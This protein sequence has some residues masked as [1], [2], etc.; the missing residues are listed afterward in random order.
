MTS[1]AHILRCFVLVVQLFLYEDVSL[2]QPRTA[3]PEKVQ[4][5]SSQSKRQTKVDQAQ[6]NR[7]QVNPMLNHTTCLQ[8]SPLSPHNDVAHCWYAGGMAWTG[9]QNKVCNN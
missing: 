6:M 3:T 9:S 8:E 5:N 2:T 4:H 7:L 1:L